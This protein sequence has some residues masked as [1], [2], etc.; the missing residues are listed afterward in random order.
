[1]LHTTLVSL[2]ALSLVPIACAQTHRVTIFMQFQNGVSAEALQQ[3]Q[4]DSEALM[5]SVGVQLD[6]RFLNDGKDY[7]HVSELVV[8]K[9]HGLCEMSSS[10]EPLKTDGALGWTHTT[11]GEVLPFTNIECDRVRRFIYRSVR[12]EGWL[13]REQA[14][15]RAMARVIAHELYHIL[16]NTMSHA[17]D[18]V[19]KPYYTPGE[20]LDAGMAFQS[21]EWK[22]FQADRLSIVA[23]SRPPTGG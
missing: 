20:L 21:G 23:G 7:D 15:G 11:D 16:T 5:E 1:M 18:G 17:A 9:F 2:F 12:R 13:A 19:A 22:K 3:M 8:A 14:L 10:L 4:L 6:W